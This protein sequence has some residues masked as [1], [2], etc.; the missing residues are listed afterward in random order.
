LINSPTTTHNDHHNG[1]LQIPVSPSVAL[2]VQ[3]SSIMINHPLIIQSII[4]LT[5]TL[6]QCSSLKST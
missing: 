1:D 3:V 6:L 2:L 5:L 4:S